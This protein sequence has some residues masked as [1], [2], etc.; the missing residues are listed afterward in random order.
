MKLTFEKAGNSV[1]P[2]IVSTVRNNEP[3]E[4]VIKC[5]VTSSPDQETVMTLTVLVK[6]EKPDEQ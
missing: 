1:Y 3:V 2:R 6:K 4:D 5:T